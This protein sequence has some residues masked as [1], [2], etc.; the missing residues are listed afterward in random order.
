MKISGGRGGF[1]MQQ[2]MAQKA[3]KP[4]GANANTRAK[5][6]GGGSD[7]DGDSDSGGESSAPQKSDQSGGINYKQLAAAV[8]AGV[9]RPPGAPRNREQNGAGGGNENGR[10]TSAPQPAQAAKTGGASNAQQSANTGA[11]QTNRSDGGGYTSGAKADGGQATF[12]KG[13]IVDLTA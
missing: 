10:D 3:N 5:N 1:I 6:A 4:N 13:D 7:N 2:L 12:A 8:N 11:G 9:V